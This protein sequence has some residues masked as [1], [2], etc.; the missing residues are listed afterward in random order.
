MSSIVTT[1][2]PPASHTAHASAA[3]SKMTF[4]WGIGESASSSDVNKVLIPNAQTRKVMAETEAGVNIVNH[5][6]LD[7]L[8]SHLDS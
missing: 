5:A 8:F 1:P 4:F 6:S 2:S 7:E 3:P